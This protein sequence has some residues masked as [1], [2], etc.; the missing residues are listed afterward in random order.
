MAGER[1]PEGWQARLK[2]AGAARFI[3]A[4][5]LIFWLCGWAVGEGVALWF[6]TKGIL[7]LMNGAPFEEGRPPMAI[8]PALA[9]GGFLLLWLSLWTLGGIAALG[10]VL[11]LLWSED[12]IIANPGGIVVVR[13]RGPFRSRRELPRDVLQCVALAT[14]NDALVAETSRERVELTRLGTHDDRRE[15]AAQLRSELSLPE[16]MASTEPAALPKGWAEAIT[17]EGERVVAIDAGTQKAQARVAGALAFVVGAVAAVLLREGLREPSV[18]PVAIFASLGAAGLTWAALWRARGRMEWK[19]G[20]GSLTLRRRFGSS[21]EAVFEARRLEI[22]ITADSDGDRW[23]TL[24]ACREAAAQPGPA[25]WLRV[26]GKSRRRITSALN[27][28]TVPRR[29][30]TWLSRAAG[31]PLEDRTSREVQEVEIAQLRDQLEKSGPLGRA[32]A[33]FIGNAIDRGRK[34]A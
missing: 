13:S 16:L 4:A 19:I 1:T 12:R 15:I 29:L 23:F 14:R 27:E 10:E 22:V 30:G 9:I 34:S 2:P 8:G 32:A 24:E 6:L 33:R 11:R 28:P 20:S 5:F 17:P 31:V 26:D 3:S 21:V 25:R 7:A 18:V